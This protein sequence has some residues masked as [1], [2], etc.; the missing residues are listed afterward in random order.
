MKKYSVDSNSW[1]PDQRLTNNTGSSNHP[2]AVV[3]KQNNIY[4]VWDDDRDGTLKIYYKKF[5]TFTQTWSSDVP[6]SNGTGSSRY[7]GIT[8]D[9]LG[10][11]HVIWQDNRDGNEE[12]YY[13]EQI[14]VTG[15]NSNLWMGYE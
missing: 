5:D 4:L 12:I 8:A 11:V 14:N 2:A 10:N 13:R 9:Y 15:I 3:D 1:L 6:I 7:P